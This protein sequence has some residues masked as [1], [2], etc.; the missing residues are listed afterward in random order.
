MSQN[1]TRTP[2]GAGV[3]F[4]AIVGPKFKHNRLTVNFI[5]PLDKATA[6][7]NAV[8][9]H[10]L[11]MGC[12]SLPDFTSLNARLDELYGASLEAGVSKFG[13]YQVMEVS[14]RFLDGRFALDNENLTEAAAVLLAGIA[15]EPKLAQDGLF[16]EKDVDLQRQYIQD[17]IEAEINDKRSYAIQQCAAFMCEGE[18]VAVKTFG[19]PE[20]AAAITRQSAM[21]AY[22]NML[23]TAPV[24]IVFTG[25]GDAEVAKKIF[26]A[27]FS[28][29]KD[30]QPV[31][32]PLIKLR[33]VAESVREK[34]ETMDLN[35]SKLVMG[36]RCGEL[37][38]PAEL[39]AAR[40]FSNLYG[41]TPFSKLF[42][43]V[44][45]RLSLC[46][47]C[48]SR[49]DLTTRLLMVDSGVEAKNKDLAQSEILA[50]LKAVADGDFTD[51]E[52]AN[53]KLLMTN[54]ILSTT[55]STV[56][57]EGWYM[58]Q[59]LRG[60]SMSPTQDIENLQKVTREEVIAA[61]KKITLDTA[62]FLKGEDETNG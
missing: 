33:P 29:L 13:G 51:E 8:V 55:D 41:G 57:L 17:T 18:P 38:T 4:S 49:F 22:R 23:K 43:N 14:I 25:S 58:A 59:I 9:P 45:E 53:T 35:Q 37:N 26:A 34:T 12:K 47:Y 1:F 56:S 48:A 60:Q 2:V 7:D 10:I 32:Y 61:A 39:T 16:T 28:A 15:L 46:Y 20:T 24:E 21:A 5:L 27:A 42:A 19:Y 62:Y 3:Y 44:R 11:R 6:S 52:L 31:G 54:S 50:Q 30:R 36:M 40:L